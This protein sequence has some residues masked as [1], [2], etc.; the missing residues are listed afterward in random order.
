MKIKFY[1]AIILIF[2]IMI[3]NIN[4]TNNVMLF[5]SLKNENS[6]SN[7]LKTE[8]FLLSSNLENTFQTRLSLKNSFLNLINFSFN[9]R[10]GGFPPVKLVNGELG[11]GPVYYNGWAKLMKL[12]NN[13]G[14][15]KFIKE[16]AQNKKNPNHK[17]EFY[18]TLNNNV[19]SAYYNDKVFNE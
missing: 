19:F 8:K 10:L 12:E 16:F 14:E 2:T 13:Y 9:E 15:K 1:T 5:N 4:H 17:D 3:S 11:K 6:N 7:L 18:F